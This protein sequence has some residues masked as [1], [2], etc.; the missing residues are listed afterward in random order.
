M[1]LAFGFAAAGIVALLLALSVASWNRTRS[2]RRGCPPSAAALHDRL[3]TSP[4]T[5]LAACAGVLVF[6][7]GITAIPGGT[8]I[9]VPLVV[10]GAFISVTGFFARVTSIELSPDGLTIR[11][12]R[13]P[14][15]TLRWHEC[16]TLRPPL[17]PVGGWRLEAATGRKTLMPSDLWGHERV[18]DAVVANAHLHYSGNAWRRKDAKVTGRTRQPTLR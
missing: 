16:L 1:L 8:L 2:L 6:A 3:R 13:I 15:F 4:L 11:Y 7:A 17:T 18:L 14:A 9:S 5:G 12:R 10:A